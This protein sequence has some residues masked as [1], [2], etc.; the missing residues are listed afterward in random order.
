MKTSLSGRSCR[1][2]EVGNK[3]RA[4]RCTQLD[5]G[6]SDGHK[7]FIDAF[8]PLLPV[9]YSSVEFR[10]M[11]VENDLLVMNPHGHDKPDD[12]G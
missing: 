1:P 11:V 2:V 4:V 7:G 5:A 6:V 3:Y 9:D 8:S 12:L 10:C